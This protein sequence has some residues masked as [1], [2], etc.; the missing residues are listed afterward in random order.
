M[1]RRGL[2]A[3]RVGHVTI[4]DA[5]AVDASNINRQLPALTSTVGLPKAEVLA[6]R[7]RQINP[8]AEI[9]PV[10][11]F[12]D[13][14]TADKYDFTQFDAV[15]DAI[16]SI[17]SKILLIMRATAAHTPLFSS[18]GAAR[19][20]DSGRVQVAEFW[21]VKGCPLARALRDRFKKMDARPARKF[22]C[23]YSDEQPV[24]QP[25]GSCM[26]VTATFGLRIASLVLAQFARK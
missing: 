13:A 10:V 7:F 18:M 17:P 14:D 20:L 15:V 23:V 8:E 6:E 9:T 24:G 19:R 5:D 11:E 22:Q 4:V 26:T 2:S 25:K 1:V 16:D 3:R 21:K 12:Y